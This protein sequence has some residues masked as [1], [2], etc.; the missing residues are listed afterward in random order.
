MLPHRSSLLPELL[1]KKPNRKQRRHDVMAWGTIVHDGGEK[2][3]SGEG[4]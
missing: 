1:T 3:Q 2:M 4:V